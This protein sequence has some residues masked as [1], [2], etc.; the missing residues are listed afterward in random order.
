MHNELC[1]RSAYELAAVRVGGKS[2]FKSSDMHRDYII[3]RGCFVA[4]SYN[5]FPSR[6]CGINPDM[7]NVS[8]HQN[9][10][11]FFN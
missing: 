6:R 2:I 4:P 1:D 11:A 7:I 10:K 9:F 5:F 8:F 3:D